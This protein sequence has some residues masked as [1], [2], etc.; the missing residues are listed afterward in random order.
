MNWSD[1]Y[2]QK[3][4]PAARMINRRLEGNKLF[5]PD[6]CVN[7]FLFNGDIYENGNVRHI[8]YYPEILEN[9]LRV[10][11]KGAAVTEWVQ[12][13]QPFIVVFKTRIENIV[14]DGISNLNTKQKIFRILRY[15][16]YYLSKKNLD[17]WSQHDNPIIRLKDCLQ[18]P[19]VAIHALWR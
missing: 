13:A 8:R 3:E 2:D 6:K 7:G 15:C 18:V 16:L 5:S 9:I 11:G 4:G 12:R 17:D 19:A 1:F 14:F 10:V